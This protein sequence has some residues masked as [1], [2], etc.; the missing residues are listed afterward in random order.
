MAQGMSR[1]LDDCVSSDSSRMAA[2]GAT[3]FK[4]RGSTETADKGKQRADQIQFL[5]ALGIA[6]KTWPALQMV[7]GTNIPAAQS[8]IEQMLRLFNMPDKQAWLGDPMQ[9]QKMT[10]PPPMLGPD[11]QP[12]MPG[13]PGMPPGLQPGMPPGGPMPPQGPPNG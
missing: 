4:P 8:T 6:M 7:I 9:W 11:G 2:G 13:A 3:M 12:M 10:M 5:Q 1:A